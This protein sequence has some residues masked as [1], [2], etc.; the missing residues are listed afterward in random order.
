MGAAR[1][2][3]PNAE[4][5]QGPIAQCEITYQ[6]KRSLPHRGGVPRAPGSRCSRW[7]G[8]QSGRD[9]RSVAAFIRPRLHEDRP[10]LPPLEGGMRLNA[11]AETIF[12]MMQPFSLPTC[13]WFG[14]VL[15]FQCDNIF[16]PLFVNVFT[17]LVKTKGFSSHHNQTKIY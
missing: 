1:W 13:T 14:I 16:I 17:K 2:G 12:L 7:R 3:A 9:L 6:P 5:N 10:G 8:G 15:I 11:L 4:V